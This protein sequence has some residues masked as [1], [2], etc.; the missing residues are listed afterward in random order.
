MLRSLVGSEMCIRDRYGGASLEHMPGAIA[1]V[2]R[3]DVNEEHPAIVA[4]RPSGIGRTGAVSV[5][6]DMGEGFGL[7]DM[8][9]DEGLL[10]LVDLAN[11]ACGFHASDPSVMAKTIA[12][13]KRHGVR[14]GAHPSF[15]DLQGFGRREMKLA[16]GELADL[17]T[18][19]VGALQGFLHTAG[20]KL[21]HV[22]PHGSLYG[23][24]SRDPAACRELCDAVKPFGVP[25]VGLAGTCH[26]AVS[27][28][29]LTLPTKRIV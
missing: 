2:R 6:A 1:E 28:T 4:V 18:Y 20:I 26:E 29:H 5:N 25:L 10:P 12:A 11:V 19:Q 13:A 21:S 17:V 27:Y 16:P 3:T 7:Y 24:T 8:G 15:Q 23:V 9:D 22:K 14:V